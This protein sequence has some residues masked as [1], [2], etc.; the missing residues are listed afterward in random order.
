MKPAPFT[1]HRPKTLEEAVATL[2]KVADD[3]GLVIAGGQSLV[4]MMALRVAY[5]SDLVDI[6]A[7]AGLDEC[8]IEESALVIGATARH[9]TFHK[10]AAPGALGQL[11]TDVARYIAHYPIRL[12]GT[13]CGS[14]AHADPASEW[15]L[16]AATLGGE[17]RLINADGE[18]QVAAADFFDG[19]MSTV[20]EA[21]EIIAETRLPLLSDQATHGFY[22]FNRRAGDFALGMALAVYDSIDGRMANVR[23]GVGGI[24]DRPRRV[25]AAE[26]LLE[27]QAPGEDVF[28]SAAAAAAQD[29][30]PMDD[31][32]TDA[33]YRRDLT[34]VAVR[35]AL[36]AAHAKPAQQS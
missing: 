15:C 4:P 21:D 36:D 25:A 14:L 34:A 35:R 22:E 19:A 23:V 7:V 3:G 6:N 17:I 33:E 1:L 28:A 9:A 30:D 13:F 20:K 31:P 5:P 16:I 18:R 8:R 27:G 24:E 32:I 29:M 26:A 12:R 10:A 11:L 2:A